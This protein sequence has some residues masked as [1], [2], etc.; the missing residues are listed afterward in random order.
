MVENE[1]D[2]ENQLTGFHM[3]DKPAVKSLYDFT[4]I[5]FIRIFLDLHLDIQSKQTLKYFRL[6]IKIYAQF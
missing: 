1:I 4:S 6:L 5:C 3:T 2:K